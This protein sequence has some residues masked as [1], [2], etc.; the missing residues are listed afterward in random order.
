MIVPP[1]ATIEVDGRAAAGARPVYVMLN[2]PRGLV[3]TSSDEHGRDTIFTCFAGASLPRLFATGRLD[4]ASEGLIMLTNDSAWAARIND[5]SMQ[6]DNTYHV[7]VDVVADADLLRRLLDGAVS[8]N[9]MLRA[10]A[11]QIIRTGEKNSW[12]EIVLNE[13]HNRHIRRMLEA[14]DIS[15]LRLIR[16]SIGSLQLGSLGKGHWRHLNPGE[17][18]AFS[19]ASPERVN[20]GR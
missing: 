1:G 20:P 18:K 2:K 19:G 3:T 7:Q 9:E 13:G 15:V 16:I 11:A 12:V 4:K 5:P 6:L 14:L 8:D 10:K 17:V